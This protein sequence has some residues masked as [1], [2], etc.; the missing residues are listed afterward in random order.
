MTIK[1]CPICSGPIADWVIRAEFSCHHCHWAL[2]ANVR[3]ASALSFA[4]AALLELAAFVVL[5]FWT[6][7]MSGALDS[8]VAVFG[9]A[10][11]FTWAV[12]FHFGLRLKPIRPQRRRG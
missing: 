4:C 8:Y 5:W 6:G 7:S 10:G 12:C 2:S 3:R 11:A 9:A 1:R